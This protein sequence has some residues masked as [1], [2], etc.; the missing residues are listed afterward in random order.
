MRKTCQIL[1]KSRKSLLPSF[2]VFATTIDQDL[3]IKMHQKSILDTIS[4]LKRYETTDNASLIFSIAEN[5]PPCRTRETRSDSQIF[6]QFLTPLRSPG[7]QNED[8][9]FQLIKLHSRTTARGY[10]LADILRL[11]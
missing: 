3:Q 1:V 10:S 5:T 8:L 2:A 6:N 11:T 9:P 4:L 7:L